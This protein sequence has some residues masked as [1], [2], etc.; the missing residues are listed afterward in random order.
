MRATYI[1]AGRWE[2][3]VGQGPPKRAWSVEAHNVY[4][5]LGLEARFP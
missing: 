1:E 5:R 4:S 2:T 3:P